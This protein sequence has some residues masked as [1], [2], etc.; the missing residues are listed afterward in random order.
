MVWIEKKICNDLFPYDLFSINDDGG[1]F[2]NVPDKCAA[3]VKNYS[4]SNIY[5]LATDVIYI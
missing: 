2:H 4:G 5:P 3:V 1:V